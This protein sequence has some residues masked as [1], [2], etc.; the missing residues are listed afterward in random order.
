[1][2]PRGPRGSAAAG[3]PMIDVTARLL[4]VED[5]VVAV[6]K[7]AGLSSIGLTLDD[8]AC[9]QHLLLRHFDRMVWGVHQLDKATSGVNL[10]VLEKRLVDARRR[11]RTPPIGEKRY[12]ALCS[13]RPALDRFSIESPIGYLDEDRRLLGV[14]PSGKAAATDVVV[15]ARGEDASLLDVRL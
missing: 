10:F 9:L 3:L 11:L 14:S 5:G 2:A 1:D 12:V 4:A 13:G 6:D 8:E 7:P 15:L